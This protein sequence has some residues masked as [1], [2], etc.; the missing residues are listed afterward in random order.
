MNSGPISFDAEVVAGSRYTNW[1][2]KYQLPKIEPRF[3]EIRGCHP[4]SINLL[5][6]KAL[7]VNNPDY[8]TPPIAWHPQDPRVIEKFSL[9]RVQLEHWRG[10]MTHK[11]WIYVPHN[12]PHLFDP[13]RVEVIATLIAGV[14]YGDR[15]RLHI[16]PRIHRTAEI[17][18]IE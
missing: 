14:R 4:G 9:T 6:D 8:T 2:L 5:L 17:I 7:R 11:A 3:A 13:F 10:G 15:F 12:S 16:P 18:V 1:A